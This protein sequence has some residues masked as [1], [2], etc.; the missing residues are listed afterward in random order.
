MR[1]QIRMMPTIGVATLV[2]LAVGTAGAQSSP[3][4]DAR[5][6]PWVGCWRTVNVPEAPGQADIRPTAACVVPSSTVP[7]GVDI[8]LFAGDSLLSSAAVPRVGASTPRV[9]DDCRGSE[10]ASWSGRES[11]LVMRAEVMCARDVKRVETGLMSIAPNGDWVQLQHLEIANN[12]VTTVGRFRFDAALT[13][14]HP[15]LRGVSLSNEGLR[16]AMGGGLTPDHVLELAKEVPAGLTQTFLA[17]YG[18]PFALN[19]KA[20]V[21]LA[22]RGMPAPVLDIMVALSNPKAFVVGAGRPDQSIG[23][24]P[25]SAQIGANSPM[26]MGN[27]G[28][29]SRCSMLDDFCYGPAGMGAWGMAWQ[30]GF[31]LDPW[32]YPVSRWGYSPFG[33]S[34]YGFS[35]FGMQ[36]GAFGNTFYGRQPIIVVTRPGGLGDP[37]NGDLGNYRPIERGRA[38]NGGGY[39]RSGGGGAASPRTTYQ[40]GGGGSS[41]GSSGG[42]S[43][44]GASG[45]GG[46]VRTAKPRGGGQ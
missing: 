9:I 27:R 30:Y 35:P 18:Q 46:E 12:A 41:A 14:R 2:T 44:G 17:E 6:Q 11:R 45:G 15:A 40:G 25:L 10:T 16:L 36:F 28:M 34:P 3:R 24:V 29:R 8:A 39:T 43:G 21:Q 4:V 38:V 20:L 1:K 33:L 31:G 37:G 23:E 7:G 42:V 32:G 19:G 26:L 22:D 5:F 13:A